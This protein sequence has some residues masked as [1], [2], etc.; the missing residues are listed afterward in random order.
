MTEH[1]ASFYVS[2]HTAALLTGKSVRTIHNWLESNV[3]QGQDVATKHH[4]SGVVKK[5]EINALSEYIQA[6]LSPDFMTALRNAEAGHA[7]GMRVVGL[8]FYESEAFS[9]AVK[10][11]E[12]AAHKGDSDAMSW[13][14][15]CYSHGLGVEENFAV[16][17]EWLSKAA[18]HGSQLAQ[19]ALDNLKIMDNFLKEH[20]LSVYG[21]SLRDELRGILKR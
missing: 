12:L 19:A 16:A 20:R 9:V 8:C 11:W 10:W 5:V 17:V 18:Q 1:E 6:P 4:P 14:W 3:I 7:D 13:L 2:T 15:Y 21:E